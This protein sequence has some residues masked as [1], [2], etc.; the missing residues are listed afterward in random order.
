[1]AP[2][3][4]ARLSHGQS[5]KTK[6]PARPASAHSVLGLALAAV[7]SMQTVTA[8]QV[9]E[10]KFYSCLSTQW[11][12]EFTDFAVRNDVDSMRGYLERKRCLLLKPDL[13]VTLADD[14]DPHAPRAEFMIQGIRFYAP[15]EEIGFR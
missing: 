7:L 5:P 13:P 4:A 11:L 14:A 2:R 10:G 3:S 1:M 15:S 6:H 12:D 8:D 9:T